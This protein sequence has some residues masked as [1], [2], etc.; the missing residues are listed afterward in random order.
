LTFMMTIP[1]RKADS[2]KVLLNDC[3][4]SKLVPSKSDLLIRS[5]NLRGLR[6]LG[7]VET[8]RFPPYP[9]SLGRE[10]VFFLE[11]KEASRQEYCSCNC[12]NGECP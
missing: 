9:A 5:L 11:W 2:Q 8:R 6:K 1:I 10:R 3:W 7:R 4:M 12:Q